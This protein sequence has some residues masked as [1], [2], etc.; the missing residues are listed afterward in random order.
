MLFF[1]LFFSNKELFLFKYATFYFY[2]FALAIIHR[3]FTNSV[4]CVRF[5]PSTNLKKNFSLKTASLFCALFMF[6]STIEMGM[7]TFNFMWIITLQMSYVLS[8]PLPYLD[9]RTMKQQ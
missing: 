7:I 2:C 9:K 4:I 5:S 1:F 3:G 6:S 8:N